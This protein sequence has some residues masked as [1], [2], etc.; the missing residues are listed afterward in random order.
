VGAESLAK[1]KSDVVSYDEGS[2]ATG[3]EFTMFVWPLR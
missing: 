3:K 2:E 1:L